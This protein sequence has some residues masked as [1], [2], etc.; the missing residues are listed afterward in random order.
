[1]GRNEAPRANRLKKAEWP[2]GREGVD[3]KID[4]SR[5]FFVFALVVVHHVF[6]IFFVFICEIRAI[7]GSPSSSSFVIRVIRL[8]RGSTLRFLPC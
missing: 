2:T 5:P 1:M 4:P 8:F 6:G 3:R 7:R